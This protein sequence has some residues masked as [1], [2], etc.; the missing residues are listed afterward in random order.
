MFPR[1]QRF[2]GTRLPRS[3]R[4]IR[5]SYFLVRYAPNNLA[6]N[7]YA[8]VAGTAVDR[9]AAVRN[10]LKRRCREILRRWPASGTDTLLVLSA[11]SKELSRRAL[12]EALEAVRARTAPTGGDHPR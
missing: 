4:A 8:V 6:T 11:R 2:P 9:R 10:K 1:R 12:A 7:R 3:A 5:T